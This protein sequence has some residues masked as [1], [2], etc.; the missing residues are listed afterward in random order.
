M[1]HWTR[2]RRKQR[3]SSL[4]C[5]HKANINNTTHQRVMNKRM[6][7]VGYHMSFFFVFKSKVTYFAQYVLNPCSS[8]NTSLHTSD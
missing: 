8:M 5:T 4:Y 7:D 3:A 6:D 1:E 2:Q